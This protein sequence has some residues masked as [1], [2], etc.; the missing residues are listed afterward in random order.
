MSVCKLVAWTGVWMVSTIGLHLR[1]CS[2]HLTR[3]YGSSQAAS[4]TS[5]AMATASEG[6][7]ADN[8]LV[9]RI[10]KNEVQNVKSKEVRPPLSVDPLQARAG[11]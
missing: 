8:S 10:A 3:L 9:D 11:A 2:T 4:L 6:A 1:K 5:R 7:A